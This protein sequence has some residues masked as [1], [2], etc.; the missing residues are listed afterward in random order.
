MGDRLV[1]WRRGEGGGKGLWRC[2]CRSAEQ[3]RT[4][5]EEPWWSVW[6]VELLRLSRSNTAASEQELAGALE[7]PGAWELY[8]SKQLGRPGWSGWGPERG[9]HLGYQ[10]LGENKMSML[11]SLILGYIIDPS[12]VKW[13]AQ[14]FL[15]NCGNISSPCL[16]HSPN[17]A[18]FSPGKHFSSLLLCNGS[19]GSFL[20]NNLK[21]VWLWKKS[22][23]GF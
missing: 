13:V 12:S 21:G 20:Q 17:P 16:T 2:R 1:I 22:Q 23:G 7:S 19:Q 10:K 3:Q 14:R 5:W 4:S 6:A 11:K 9:C 8:H 18:A 15:E